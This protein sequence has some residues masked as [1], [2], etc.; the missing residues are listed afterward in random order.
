MSWW[1]LS[2]ASFRMLYRDGQV[3]LIAFL[4]PL[5]FVIAFRL[6]D[7]RIVVAGAPALRDGADGGTGYFE[8][9]LPGLLAID[10]KS[11]V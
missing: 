9:V 3:L 8:F 11:V 4:I 10:R 7:L 6:F 1:R 2:V 5:V